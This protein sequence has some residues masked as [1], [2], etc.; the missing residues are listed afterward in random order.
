VEKL[1]TLDDVLSKQRVLLLVGSNVV[2]HFCVVVII[3]SKLA[4]KVLVSHVM[5]SLRHDVSVEPWRRECFVAMWSHLVRLMRMELYFP[6]RRSA[7]RPFHVE[8]TDA[9]ISVILAHVGSVNCPLQWSTLAHVG[10]KS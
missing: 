6:A 10:K 7:P 5:S 1:P 3:V 4:M 2:D 9:R 8:T